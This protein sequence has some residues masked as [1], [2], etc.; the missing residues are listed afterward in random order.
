MPQIPSRT[1][2]V[3]Y[4]TLEYEVHVC[5]C[6]C[7][8]VCKGI[9]KYMPIYMCVYIYMPTYIYRTYIFIGYISD[10]P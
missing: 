8:C 1:S 2:F 9:Y 5:V 7:V 10:V 3:A 6:V 4:C